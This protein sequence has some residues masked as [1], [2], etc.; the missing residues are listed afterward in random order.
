ME[1]PIHKP[2]GARPARGIGRAGVP[3]E[4]LIYDLK[5]HKAHCLNKTAALVWNHCDGETSVSEMATLLQKEAAPRLAKKLSGTLWI[6]WQ[7]QF[8][9]EAPGDAE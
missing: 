2:D 7:G 8:V 5:Q 3:D 9:G 6:S 4:V 1:N